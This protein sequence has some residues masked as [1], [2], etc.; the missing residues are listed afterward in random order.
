MGKLDL[1]LLCARPSPAWFLSCKGGR[2]NE[3]DDWFS[4]VWW[5]RSLGVLSTG[6]PQ[7]R[8]KVNISFTA[9]LS[10]SLRCGLGGKPNH[11]PCLQLSMFSSR[12]R[13]SGPWRLLSVYTSLRLRTR[14]KL[15][16]INRWLTC[17]FQGTPFECEC[18][19][20]S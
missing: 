1:E 2:F 14:L 20:V 9:W 19:S 6:N 5:E 15:L 11:C 17:I 4:S 3:E 13:L 18:R 7:F 8:V 12:F 10:G 16:G